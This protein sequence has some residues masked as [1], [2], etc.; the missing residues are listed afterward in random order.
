MPT[1]YVV[2]YSSNPETRNRFNVCVMFLTLDQNVHNLRR[3]VIA[4]LALVLEFRQG[5]GRAVVRFIQSRHIRVSVVS[6]S[7]YYSLRENT[8]N[9]S[10][11][12]QLLAMPYI[13]F[14]VFATITAIV[15]KSQ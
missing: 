7:S 14:I 9:T 1:A 15:S 11:L 3:F 12:L 2:F 8:N 13:I 10:I 4:S 6:I 5:T